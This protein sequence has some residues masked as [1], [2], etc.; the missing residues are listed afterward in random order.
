MTET[1]QKTLI[2]G[3]EGEAK[4]IGG[5]ST[6]SKPVFDKM[7]KAKI[8]EVSFEKEPETKKDKRGTEYKPCV[9]KVAFAVE[10]MQE[11]ANE[12][13][14]FSVYKNK[15]SAG[16]D[17]YNAFY[18]TEKSKGG[19]LRQLVERTYGLK[20]SAPL[21]E[22]MAILRGKECVIKSED[23]SFQGKGYKKIVVQQFQL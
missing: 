15:D 7:T 20:S 16:N 11:P 17:S 6:P 10:G 3:T 13:Y 23:T 4:V 2:P 8:V 22:Y 1:E 18:G 21:D 12:F 19:A 5:Q 9:L 14:T